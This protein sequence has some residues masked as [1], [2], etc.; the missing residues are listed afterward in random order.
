[1]RVAVPRLADIIG[2]T[3]QTP[4]TRYFSASPFIPVVLG[5]DARLQ[6]LHESDAVGILEHLV[7]SDFAGI[8]NVAGDGVLMLSQAIH[9]AGRIPLPVPNSMLSRFGTAV[10]VLRLGKFSPEQVRLL[11]AGRV[12]DT[13]RL[14]AEAGF[15]PHF[16]TAAAFDDFAYTLVPAIDRDSVRRAEL[17]VASGLGLGGQPDAVTSVVPQP[18]PKLVGIS[19]EKAGPVG[20]RRRRS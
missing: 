5:H 8:V 6:L 14:R 11:V 13:G 20:V 18:K 12:V 2:P 10:R 1:M 17:R 16:T 19:G 7:F 3:A 4:L 15:V 9:R